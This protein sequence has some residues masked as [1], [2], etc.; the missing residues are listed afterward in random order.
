LTPSDRVHLNLVDSS[1]QLFGL[2][3]GAVVEAGP[4]YVLCAGSHS[5]PI[6]SNAVFRTDDGLDANELLARAGEFFGGRG[7]GFSVWA[8]DGLPEDRDLQ[9]TAATAGLQA[10]YA[11]PEMVL[12]GPLPPAPIPAG[13][14]LRQLRSE[15]E[16]GAYWKVAAASYA[17]LGFPPDVFDYYQDRAGLLADN[18]GAFIAY[19]DG[20]PVSIAMTIVSHRVAG[21]YWVGSLEAARGRGLGRAVTAA[22]TNSGFELG[23][24][25]AS[26]QASHMGRPIY[27]AMGFETVFD[28]QLLL[29]PP[30]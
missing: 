15:D 18:V 8:R 28:Y 25:V 26:L 14:E 23:A 21:I 20:E 11:M 1:R 12:K 16:V 6:I 3:A 13:A 27:A 5:N 29:S 19:L 22:A 9:A 7:R 17:S 30:P 2:D 4:G 24:D 10:V